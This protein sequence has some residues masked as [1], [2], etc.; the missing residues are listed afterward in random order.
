MIQVCIYDEN[1]IF[2]K[3]AFV[4]KLEENM[5]TIPF[6]TGYYKPKFNKE[7]QEWFEGAT[8]EE[9]EEMKR[10]EEESRPPQEPSEIEILEEKVSALEE[11]QVVQ[12]FLIDDLVFEVIP[13]LEQQISVGNTPL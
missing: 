9:I 2:I 8:E 5:T 11:S 13:T 6:S 4:E 3:T 10:Q 7:T 12:D 1:N